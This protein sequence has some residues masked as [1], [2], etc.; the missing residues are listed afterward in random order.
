MNVPD[1]P[2]AV[3]DRVQRHASQ[4]E[5][6]DFL[7]VSFRN[8]L[9]WVR[10]ARVWEVVFLPISH[11]LFDG[12]RP[13]RQDFSFSRSKLCIPIPQARQLRAAIRSHEPAQESQHD[14]FLSTE[15][16]QADLIPIQIGQRKIRRFLPIE[17]C[18]MHLI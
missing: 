6:V 8:P 10:Q 18:V 5:Q 12:I 7:F 4:F 11:M 14:N 9:V 1:K 13:N 15:I 2:H 16:G 17:N 3:Y